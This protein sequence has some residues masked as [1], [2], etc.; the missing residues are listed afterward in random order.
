[1]VLPYPYCIVEDHHDVA[2]EDCWTALPQLFFSCNLRPKGGRMP[3]NLRHKT[4]LDDLRQDLVFFSTFK[5]L[6]LPIKGPMEDA[7]VVKLYEP[8]LTPCLYVAHAR[9]MV[10]RISL[11]PCFLDGNVTPTIPHKYSKNKNSCFPAG[12]AD[13]AAEDGRRG[14][15]VSEVNTFLWQFGRDKPSLGGLTIKETSDRH[16]SARKASYK[17]SEGD[18]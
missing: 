17:P 4:G 11:M 7:G 18:S 14:S 1:M 13:A 8:S 3:K 5:E 16:D 10:G 15:N 2:L 12:C 9:N 6:T